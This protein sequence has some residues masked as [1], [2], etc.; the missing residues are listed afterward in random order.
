MAD[1]A[2]CR[3]SRRFLGGSALII[4]LAIRAR[5]PSV[6]GRWSTSGSFGSARSMPPQD[7]C[8]CQALRCTAR[9]CSYP[10]YFQQVRG[11]QA[12]AAGLLIAAQGVGAAGSRSLA[13][14]LTDQIGA[15]WV[16]FT[17]LVVVALA[18]LPF[19][20][21]SAHTPEWCL[22]ATIILRGIGLGAISIPVMCQRLHRA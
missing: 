16:A 4:A 22:V 7:C 20:L 18:T 1:S 19:A 17:G 14:R 6:P 9:C 10:L 15:R 3:C 8:S 21:A 12:F 2:T 5:W 13:G 11:Q